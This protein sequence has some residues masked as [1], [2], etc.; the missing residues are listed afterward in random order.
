MLVG[1]AKAYLS[2]MPCLFHSWHVR[3]LERS[4]E[5]LLRDVQ[6][7]S[8]EMKLCKNLVPDFD[9]THTVKKNQDSNY[10]KTTRIPP[11]LWLLTETPMKHFQKHGL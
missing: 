3:S 7:S 4:V 5:D 9:F 6:Y 8:P 11:L 10:A 1:N 2:R